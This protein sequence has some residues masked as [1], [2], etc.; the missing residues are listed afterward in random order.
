MKGGYVTLVMDALDWEG[1]D[2]QSAENANPPRMQIAANNT[3][4]P[5]VTILPAG[6]SISTAP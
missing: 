5:F 1:T 3:K 6:N 2:L 4:S